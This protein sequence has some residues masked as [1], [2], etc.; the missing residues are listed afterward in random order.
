MTTDTLTTQRTLVPLEDILIHPD[1]Q[2]RRKTK[3]RPDGLREDFVQKYTDI[4]ASGGT[5]REPIKV[6]QGRQFTA[7]DPFGMAE[8]KYK[9]LLVDGFHRL[10][11]YKRYF[12][13]N[14]R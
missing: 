4:L 11:A 1:L 10:K 2:V 3:D 7:T 6:I 14:R 13:N 5:F 8:T 12:E 9:Y